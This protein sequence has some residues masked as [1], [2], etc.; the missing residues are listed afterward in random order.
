MVGGSVRRRDRVRRRRLSPVIGVAHD[1][2]VARH[3]D[4]TS[5]CETSLD[6]SRGNTRLAREWK[7]TTQV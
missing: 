4:L 5:V 2:D 3:A 1:C 6:R 7:V